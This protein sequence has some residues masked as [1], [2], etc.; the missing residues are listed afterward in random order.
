M[1]RTIGR[2][3]RAYAELDEAGNARR[4]QPTEDEVAKGDW[5]P[6]GKVIFPT[7]AAAKQFAHSLQEA[8]GL[9]HNVYEC[10]R[11]GHWHTTTRL[12]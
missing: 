6:G 11:R 7:E 2:L 10:S 5:K 12:T 1:P 3:K 8:G 9:P 4:C